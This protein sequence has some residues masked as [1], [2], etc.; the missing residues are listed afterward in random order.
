MFQRIKKFLFC[1]YFKMVTSGLPFFLMHFNR[2]D[3]ATGRAVKKSNEAKRR[4]AG[5]I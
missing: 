1:F 3:A 5:T 2:S 4:M